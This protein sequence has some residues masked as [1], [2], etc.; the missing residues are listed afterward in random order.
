MLYVWRILSLLAARAS[1]LSSFKQVEDR[2]WCI[3]VNPQFEVSVYR[4]LCRT[5]MFFLQP[6][7]ECM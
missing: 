7:C 6:W 3:M 2:N 4:G 1:L 5:I